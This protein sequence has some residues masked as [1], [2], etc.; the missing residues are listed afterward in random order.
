MTKESRKL[1]TRMARHKVKAEIR[2]VQPEWLEE[3]VCKLDKE[4]DEAHDHFL[5]AKKTKIKKAGTK[6]RKK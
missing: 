4:I 2:K 1:Q 6:R 5:Y 3:W